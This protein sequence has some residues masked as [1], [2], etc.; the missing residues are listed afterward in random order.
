MAAQTPLT[1][2]DFDI[3]GSESAFQTPP[4]SVDVEKVEIFDSRSALFHARLR[5]SG[6]SQDVGSWKF[7]G[8]SGGLVECRWVVGKVASAAR[9]LGPVH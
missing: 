4:C 5:W 3:D 8:S 6:S 2:M 1:A 9:C 7:S